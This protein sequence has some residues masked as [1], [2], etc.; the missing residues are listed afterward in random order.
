MFAPRVSI[1]GELVVETPLHLG[2]GERAKLAAHD[3]AA[4]DELPEID[5]LCHCVRGLP[6]LPG[7][8]LKG[9]LRALAGGAPGVESLFGLAHEDEGGQM[10]SLVV[11]GASLIG[12]GAFPSDCN[13]PHA[14]NGRSI[15]ARSARHEGRDVAAADRGALFLAEQ[16]P[17][18]S[19][20]LFRARYHAAL[21]DNEAEALSKALLWR[22]Q[23]EG[24]QLGGGRSYGEGR[25]KLE[26]VKIHSETLSPEGVLERHEAAAWLS[27]VVAVEQRVFGSVHELHLCCDGPFYVDDWAY[28]T[29][30]SCKP[31]STRAA[32]RTQRDVQGKPRLDGASVKGALRARCAWRERAG[33]GATDAPRTQRL[34]GN[35]RSAA[36][37]QVAVKCISG[38]EDFRAESVS[39]DRWSGGPIDGALFSVDAVFAP[40]FLVTLRLTSR[41]IDTREQREADQAMLSS[42]LTDV[43]ENGVELGHSVSSGFGWFRVRGAPAQ[44]DFQDVYASRF[45]TPSV[46]LSADTY[47]GQP[48]PALLRAPYRFAYLPQA[49]ARPDPTVRAALDIK[50]PSEAEGWGARATLHS[51]PLQ[52][53]LSG[54]LE[55]KWRA[56]SPLL[57][58]QTRKEGDV[59]VDEPV[60]LANNDYWIPGASIK[61]LVRACAEIAGYGR[62]T[63]ANLDHVFAFRDFSKAEYS[64]A[65]GDVRGGW[66]WREN[67]RYFI[68]DAGAPLK[69]S[70]ESLIAQCGDPRITR[71][72]WLRHRTSIQRYELM[73]DKRPA[74]KALEPRTR[75]FRATGNGHVTPD[76]HG[77]IEGCLVLANN[78]PT[79]NEGNIEGRG[80]KRYEH[81]FTVRPERGA[82]RVEVP[83]RALRRFELV[84]TRPGKRSAREPV[85]TWK[86]LEPLL[87]GGPIPVFYTGELNSEVADI[88]FGVTRAFKIAHKQCVGDALV[89]AGHQPL[90]APDMVE[91]LFGYV[92]ETDKPRDVTNALKSRLRFS[93]ARIGAASARVTANIETVMMGSR[94]SFAPFY[95][96]GEK[97]WSSEAALP[98]GRKRYPPRSQATLDAVR[99]RLKQQLAMGGGEATRTRLKLLTDAEGTAGPE[100]TSR[101]RFHNVTSVEFGLLLF[102][103]THGGHLGRA[104][105]YRHAIGRA[106]PFG[107]GKI[108]VEAIK[109][110]A[111][112]GTALNPCLD[113]YLNAFVD[114]MNGGEL[115]FWG[116]EAPK[117]G[118]FP[119]TRAIHEWLYSSNPANSDGG[120]CLEGADAGN[121][122]VYLQLSHRPNPYQ[123]L[124]KVG[125]T[126]NRLLPAAPLPQRVREGGEGARNVRAASDVGGGESRRRNKSRRRRT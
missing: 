65:I 41:S 111:R 110:R 105:P 119:N 23:S 101:I 58:G 121:G 32:S 69:V 91:A 85:G 68:Q 20:F 79:L 123:E 71:F 57:V 42:L 16:V 94:A 99:A 61:G 78:Q 47:S 74:K 29:K 95:L 14:E 15:M 63:R 30:R 52:G 103:L 88:N 4:Q 43:R 39:L 75:R 31:D 86:V 72:H 122:G 81:V 35:T 54:E 53:G 117:L 38:G 120:D 77:T 73:G 3:G 118:E 55:I 125:R 5:L 2:S 96:A 70:I 45:A 22:I 59:D 82:K 56:E 97:N 7:S 106:K 18:G 80:V 89:R 6:F 115:N 21:G 17:P 66:L 90:A 24:L 51:R 62:L 44:L 114:H 100:F 26:S 40:E 34:F 104:N 50:A 93:G 109:M 107:A 112:D 108:R 64:R 13:L 10:G 9:A 87:D 27:G 1:E 37:L 98:A 33:G 46:T 84:N 19:R 116:D 49:V 12:D 11:F 25:V 36:R 67:G 60:V 76:R 126:P 28:R 102:A 92:W 113:Q 124:R 8:S 48:D 83:V